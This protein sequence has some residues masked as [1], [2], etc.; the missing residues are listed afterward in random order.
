MFEALVVDGGETVSRVPPA[1][2]ELN[3]PL[4]PHP[5]EA[6]RR[7]VP[8]S[9]TVYVPSQLESLELMRAA[10][11]LSHARLFGVAH[12]PALHSLTPWPAAPLGDQVPD[13]IVLALSVKP[14]MFPP[15]GRQPICWYGDE[16]VAV[17]PLLQIEIS[18]IA[19]VAG[20]VYDGEEAP[21]WSQPSS[22]TARCSIAVRREPVTADGR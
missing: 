4:A 7:A 15:E 2:L 21:R 18:E 17:I 9:S 6:V 14:W 8:A 11:A 1:F 10:W 13:L 20:F 12:T 16:D 19:A 3:V 22:H 5:Y